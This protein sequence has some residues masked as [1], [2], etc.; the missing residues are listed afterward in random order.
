MA[1]HTHAAHGITMDDLL[2]K[3]KKAGMKSTTPR[4]AILTV[5]LQSHGPHTAE[6]VHRL[7]STKV[8]DLVTVYRTLL[9][10]EESKILRKCEFGD[11]IARFELA[12]D[13]HTHHHHL[14]CVDCKRVDVIDDEEI[15]LI[16]RFASKR[17]FKNI[18]HSLE[19][20][21]TCPDC[22]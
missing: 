9:N 11:R 20:F 2:A 15:E 4:K 8:C 16:D 10:L 22:A 17:G 18:S 14:I 12:E 7:I 13:E 6:E 21:G 1:T 3:M 19:F 5:F